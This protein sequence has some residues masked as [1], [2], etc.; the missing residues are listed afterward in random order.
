MRGWEGLAMFRTIRL[1]VGIA[2]S[3]VL[4]M[5]PLMLGLVTFLYLSVADLMRDTALREMERTTES[6]RVD[7]QTLMKP[8]A[9]FV[10][11]SAELF[12]SDPSHLRDINELGYYYR[13][14]QSLPQ[15]SSVY[16]GFS[17][18][19]DFSQVFHLPSTTRS[20][21]PWQKNWEDGIDYVV[22]MI[23]SSG[24]RREDSYIF[25]KGWGN[26][27][28]VE[29]VDA[30]YDPR[31]RPWFKDA[32]WKFGTA[33]SNAYVFD[34]SKV[35]GMTISRA[36]KTSNGMQIGVVGADIT[37][38]ALS[39]FVRDKALGDNGRV[40]LLDDL[41]HLVAHADP[42][43]GVRMAGS[44][45][46]LL[47]AS[48]V[49]DKVVAQAVTQWQEQ[50]EDKYIGQVRARDCG[51]R[52]ICTYLASITAIDVGADRKWYV[53]VL[54]DEQ[55]FIGPLQHISVQIIFAG[56][57]GLLLAIAAIVY[58]SKGL[59]KPIKC[60][61]DKTERIQRFELDGELKVHS[62][63]LE[64]CQLTEAVSTMTRS[65]RSFSVYVPRDLVRAI[66]SEN[67][68]AALVSR[69]Q[70]LT[71]MMTDIQGYT[72]ISEAQAPEEVVAHLNT[73]FERMTA[74]IHEHNGIV[75]KYIGDA[76]MAVWNAPTE[77]PYHVENACRAALHCQKM[78]QI[79]VA[80]AEAEG[81]EPY[82]TRIGLHT[83]DAVIGNV[84]SSDRMQ[85]SAI[86][87]V[88][89][90]AARLEALN[91]KYGT[92]LLVSEHVASMVWDRFLFR[93]VD[94]VV[95]VG[96]SQPLNI[97]ELVAEKKPLQT[98]DEDVC[99][100][101]SSA[102][103]EEVEVVEDASLLEQ[104]SL[105]QNTMDIYFSQR[106]SEALDGFLRYQKMVA[107]AADPVVQVFIERCEIYQEHPPEDGW[108]GAVWLT[109][110]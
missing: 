97:Y 69:R 24:G 49:D 104:I 72:Q 1:R 9:Q 55:D 12:R 11:A 44:H 6:V 103:V 39:R 41:G 56:I 45:V 20:L 51:S 18:S 17:K 100:S 38:D 50:S 14:L 15:V 46:E 60:I 76:I 108:D 68:S 78:S 31:K 59:T 93:C 82:I 96:T 53:G 79:L 98:T 105:W 43:M 54:V 77:D 8:V 83:G 22:R 65:L 5:L 58:L 62:R 71:V 36:V 13:R 95:P 3:Y 110:K 48:E 66:V 94:R 75:D 87:A 33:I 4:I 88:I 35:I 21:G 10:E 67:G 85:Y 16:A 102:P 57:A 34:S 27:R 32:S 92:T 26:V 109:S 29:R 47:M 23:D 19:G 63:I 107:P 84:G 80:E 106:W 86:G 30:V 25:Y 52:H 70:P 90:L 101:E 7:L 40:F 89:N 81:R 42:M 37:L 73:Y 28:H 64:V 74:E 61:V 91:K 2:V 99:I